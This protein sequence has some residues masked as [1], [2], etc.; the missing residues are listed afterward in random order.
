MRRDSSDDEEESDEEPVNLLG[1]VVDP[2]LLHG[3]SQS[4]AYKL[5]YQLN[6]ISIY[7][8]WCMDAHHMP[9]R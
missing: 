6:M 8:R 3:T 7:A 4:I 9:G 1:K 5:T 2:Q